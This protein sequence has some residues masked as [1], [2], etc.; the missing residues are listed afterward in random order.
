MTTLPDSAIPSGKVE[1]LFSPRLISEAVQKALPEGY[2]LRPLSAEDYHKGF[3]NILA[4]LSV[5][6][7]VPESSFLE[8]YQH[9]KSQK[10]YFVNVIEEISTG[11]VVASATLIAEYKFLHECGKIGHIED[12]VVSDTQ[13]GKRFGIR[14][15]EQLKWLAQAIGC[16][17]VILNCN[18]HNVPFYSKCGLKEKDVQMACYFDAMTLEEEIEIESI[19]AQHYEIRRQNSMGL[20]PK[21][22]RSFNYMLQ[23]AKRGEASEAL[24]GIQL[25]DEPQSLTIQTKR[26]R[27]V[28]SR[29]FLTIRAA[30]APNMAVRGITFTP[31]WLEGTQPRSHRAGVH[32]DHESHST[33]NGASQSQQAKDIASESSKLRTEASSPMKVADI[34]P[35]YAASKSQ[36][37]NVESAGS[38]QEPSADATELID[39]V[40]S[41]RLSASPNYQPS[42][43]AYRGRSIPVTSVNPNTSYRRLN[44]ILNENGIRRELR[45]HDYYEKPTAKRRRQAIQRNRKLFAEA[46]RRK[47]GLIMQMKSSTFSTGYVH[48]DE[49]FQSPEVMAGWI[50]KYNVFVPWEFQTGNPARSVVIP[51]LTTGSSFAFQKILC[52]IIHLKACD[53]SAAVF[54]SSRLPFFFISLAIGQFRINSLQQ[55]VIQHEDG[56]PRKAWKTSAVYA[57]ADQLSGPIWSIGHCCHHCGCKDF[58]DTLGEFEL[59][60]I[61]D[62]SCPDVRNFDPFLHAAPRGQISNPNAGANVYLLFQLCSRH[63]EILLGKQL[64]WIV[65]N[66]VLAIVFGILHQGGIVPVLGWLRK[67]SQ[68]SACADLDNG[69]MACDWTHVGYT[70]AI[71]LTTYAY[72]YKTYMPPRYLLLQPRDEPVRVHVLDYA[73]RNFSEIIQSLQTRAP[74]K[75]T[76]MESNSKSY[77]QLGQGDIE[78]FS[79]SLLITPAVTQ[80]PTQ[81]ILLDQ[82]GKPLIQ[83]DDWKNVGSES[84]TLRLVHKQWHHVNFDDIGA[85]LKGPKDGLWL[86][87]WQLV[88]LK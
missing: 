24:A 60:A 80:F 31:K 68:S 69:I 5:V 13:R 77:Y 59:A 34:F 58:D 16:Y 66:A 56:K 45:M 39:T 3:L 81:V 70:R 85:V 40:K 49:F 6:G 12:V 18:T 10:S 27:L 28:L 51:A 54:I 11:K 48:P 61:N 22:E 74:M 8:R 21:A 2:I 43:A 29:P 37:S 78:A 20:S 84:I 38:K 52:S 79:R 42:L 41:P 82:Q 53:T 44:S 63:W 57:P 55:P 9:M 25:S 71:N 33:A 23:E 7:N 67:S 36:K 30:F 83:R 88:E 26:N 17:K 4:Q 32:D 50:Y 14:L 46:V 62:R 64:V 1:S 19:N 47:V 73:G 15:V 87:V 72:F 35:L 65:F 76:A 86:N 75:S